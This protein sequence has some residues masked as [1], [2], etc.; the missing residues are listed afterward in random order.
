VRDTIYN[1]SLWRAVSSRAKRRDE[2][3]CTVA[4]LLGGPCKGDLHAH[5]IVPVADGGAAYDLDNVGTTCAAHHPQW[6]SLRRILVRRQLA[7]QPRCPHQ[8]RSAEARRICEERLA[9]TRAIA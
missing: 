8:H 2:R 5:H 9:R 3:R 4:K 7:A 1:T 6:E